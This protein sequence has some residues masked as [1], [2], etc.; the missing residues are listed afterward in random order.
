M[1]PPCSDWAGLTGLA[2]YRQS[3]HH[4]RNSELDPVR[5]KTALF[6]VCSRPS[7]LANLPVAAL[8]LIESQ[9]TPPRLQLTN[10]L[11]I[12]R[13]AQC[14]FYPGI[15][16]LDELCAAVG[17]SGSTPPRDPGSPIMIGLLHRRHLPVKQMS[18]IPMPSQPLSLLEC[19]FPPR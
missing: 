6:P 12:I 11:F 7:L 15:N 10:C 4:S 8:T 17:R 13:H 1:N 5:L 16:R 2:C 18:A 3:I 14:F 19:A 9:Q